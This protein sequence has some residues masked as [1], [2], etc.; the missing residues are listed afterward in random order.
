MSDAYIGSSEV[1]VPIPLNYI[2]EPAK[3]E[4]RQ[5]TLDGS[6][7]VNYA[8]TTGD[9]AITKYH[10]ELPGITQFERKAI[11]AQ[12]LKTGNMSYIDHIQIP[13]ILTCTGTTGGTISVNLLRNLGT[14][15][16]AT[17]NFDVTLNS[18]GQTYTTET[19]S[20]GFF[21]ITTGGA[22]T[23]GPCT[24]GT[25]NVTVNYIPDYTVHILSDTHELMY[26]T[27]TGAHVT[28]YNL[29]LEEG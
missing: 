4:T 2:H 17:E 16:T 24:G 9:Q 15:S 25:N 19:V 23:F 5:R 3:L 13:E 12:A 26:K 29:V 8:V 18:S 7:I 6:M 14:S 21:S 28:R 1:T 10:F 20:S 11:R 22:V 27:S